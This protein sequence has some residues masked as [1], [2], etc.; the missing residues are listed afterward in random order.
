MHRE[1][2]LYTL[3]AQQHF[4]YI[5]HNDYWTTGNVIGYF[6]AEI[7]NFADW[8][9][10][11]GQDASSMNID[12]MY[13]SDIDLHINAGTTPIL[14]ESGGALITGITTDIDEDVRPGPLGSVNG[15]ALAPDLG[16]D[17]FDGVPVGGATF[18]LSVDVTNGWNMVSIPGLHPVDQNVLTWWSGKDPS[19]GVFR[20]SGG[21]QPITTATPGQ[22]YWMKTFRC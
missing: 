7:A 6:G 15:G 18:Q 5:N 12:P 3:Q 22:G 19:A 17:E 8:Q 11:T 9:T 20:F 16:A 21:Y 10:A 1:I 14:L 2:M 4:P 13:T